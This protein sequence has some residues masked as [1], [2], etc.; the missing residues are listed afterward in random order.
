MKNFSILGY[1][2]IGRVHQQAIE[3]TECQIESITLNSIP[4]APYCS[5]C[6]RE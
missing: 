6:S 5:N 3:E 1:G 2:H 4:T